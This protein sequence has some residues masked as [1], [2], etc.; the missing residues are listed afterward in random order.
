M[1][2]TRSD[3]P[4]EIDLQVIPGTYVAV[5]YGGKHTSTKQL[6]YSVQFF[7]N[8]QARLLVFKD[9]SKQPSVFWGK[10][11]QTSD[12]VIILYFD[13]RAM[14]SEFFKKRSD[15]NLSILQAN[16]KEYEGQMYEYMVAIKIQ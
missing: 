1:Q 7:E 15:G 13:N 6:T 3:E 4:P 10:W 5:L 2:E 9:D 12:N 14:A 16:R 11:L 8:K